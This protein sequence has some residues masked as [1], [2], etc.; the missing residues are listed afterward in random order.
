MMVLRGSMPGV[1]E[2]L[3]DVLQ[4]QELLGLLVDEGARHVVDVDGAGMWP[5]SYSSA[6]RTSHTMA[7][8]YGGLEDEIGVDDGLAPAASPAP[9]AASARASR[10]ARKLIGLGYQLA[11]ARCRSSHSAKD[12]VRPPF[13]TVCAN[14]WATILELR[15]L[16][17][18]LHARSQRPLEVV[19]KKAAVSG[20]SLTVNA[21][22]I[23]GLLG[24]NGAGKSTT[25][26]MLCGLTPPDQGTVTVGGVPVGDDASP[27][28]RR[29]GLVPQDI[30]LY[31]DLP[32]LAN[33]E[34]FG[35]LY[36]VKGAPLRQRAA[37]PRA[38]GPLRP[39][40]GQALDL[41]RRH[42]AP[43]QHRLR[44]GARSR[45]AAARRAHRG[46]R[47]PEPQRH[48]RQP[49]GAARAR[50]GAALHHALHGGGRAPLR[51]HR[52][53]GP[54]QVVASDRKDALLDLL[55]AEKR[56]RTVV[57]EAS[58]EDVFLHLTGRELRD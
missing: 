21:G 57:R 49:R 55:P 26:A 25:V 10:M 28:K 43:P 38:R 17:Q 15:S 46:R 23:V 40:Q 8:A 1:A 54:R 58:L 7:P 39:R 32:A 22:E 31:E 45:R 18:L 41:Q 33:L 50:Q 36:G 53:R 30:S 47:S 56:T 12:G 5:R 27:T 9:G 34:L 35:A 51:P 48:L 14:G 29:I 4:R 24:P 37:A 20:V 44:A 3:L 11:P 16:P 6:R 42:E 19:R 52:D 2:A 13:C